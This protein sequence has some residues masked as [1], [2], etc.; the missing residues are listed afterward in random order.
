MCVRLLLAHARVVCAC[1][2]KGVTSRSQAGRAGTEVQLERE[3]SNF[4]VE[5][6]LVV[7]V[8][9]VI[10][11]KVRDGVKL[12]TGKTRGFVEVEFQLISN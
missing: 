10:F 6:V 7:I 9:L 2:A 11:S 12:D 8:V 4:V 3:N 1:G 5:D